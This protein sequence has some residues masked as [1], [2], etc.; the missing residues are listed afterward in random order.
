MQLSLINNIC[1]SNQYRSSIIL[2]IELSGVS[3][4]LYFA[5]FLYTISI[6]SCQ[7]L[8]LRIKFSSIAFILSVL[9]VVYSCL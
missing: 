8:I 9:Y 7:R 2:C 3:P 4:F 6:L 5:F 1:R